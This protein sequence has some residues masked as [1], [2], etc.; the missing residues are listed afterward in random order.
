MRRCSRGALGGRLGVAL[1][2][3]AA[4]ARTGDTLEVDI[5][6][7]LRAAAAVVV[8]ASIRERAAL[9]VE[10]HA[11][12]CLG[13]RRVPQRRKARLKIGGRLGTIAVNDAKIVQDDRIIE[14][15][16]ARDRSV[17]IIPR[18]ARFVWIKRSLVTDAAW[19]EHVVWVRGAQKASQE[20]E[21][22]ITTRRRR[23]GAAVNVA[24]R[25]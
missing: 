20:R 25:G 11:L 23:R 6:H 18:P 4:G 22:H 7:D 21:L 16:F 3:D 2:T 17:K 15:P 12:F 10:V 8:A 19:G 24:V 13:T 9:E 1:R 5:R 14:C